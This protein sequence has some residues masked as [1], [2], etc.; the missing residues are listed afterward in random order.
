MQRDVGIAPEPRVPAE[1]GVVGAR[2][3]THAIDDRQADRDDKSRQN[4]EHD[5]AARRD[6]G[7]RDLD[8]IDRGE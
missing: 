6:G 2:A 1:D 4:A 8:R 3:A 5:D 7:D